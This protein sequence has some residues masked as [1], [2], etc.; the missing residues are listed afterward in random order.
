MPTSFELPSGIVSG[1]T[2][3]GTSWSRIGNGPTLVLLHGV[4]MNKAVW[5]PEVNL[6]QNQFEVLI[7]DMWGHGDSDLPEGE[8]ALSDYTKQLVDLL[9]ELNIDSAFVAGHSMGAL[10]ALDFALLHPDI[11]QAV[12]AM[13][14]VFNR[15][16]EQSAS[17]Q[18]RAADLAAGGVSV[19][20]TETLERWF[21]KSGDH[22]FVDA[23]NLSRELLL[24]VN[25]Q[26]YSAAYSV[27]ANS[28]KAHLGKLE[29]LKVPALFFTADGD[30]N[31]TAQM[32]LA[33]AAMAPSGSAVVL[34][35][36]RHM[37]TLTAP[38]E[39]A[40]TLTTFFESSTS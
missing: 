22:E 28:D 2:S 34:Q 36:H 18:K 33:M 38:N 8:L 32:S 13:N 31:S 21:G 30:P 1:K 17:V 14:A 24:A 35:G 26:G 15:T 11:C 6:L 3:T 4:G 19:N 27:F 9:S 25:P 7:Y 23:E 10:I 12:C 37:M 39:V 16:A 5:A 20:L 29:N 40:A